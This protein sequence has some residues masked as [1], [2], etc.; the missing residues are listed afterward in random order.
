[1]LFDLGTLLIGTLAAIFGY[2]MIWIWSRDMR[3][4]TTWARALVRISGAI[5]LLLGLIGI[6][7]A[8]GLIHLAGGD[9][10]YVWIPRL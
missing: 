6:A 5:I 4:E 9:H 8:F 3:G 2:W 7:K 1:M 10:W